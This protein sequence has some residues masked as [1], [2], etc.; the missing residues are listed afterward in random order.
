MADPLSIA[1]LV[2]GVIS[3]GLQVADGLTD[4]LDAVKGR[5]EDLRS[6]KQGATEMRDL[7]STIRDLSPQVESSWPASATTVKRHV[8]SCQIELGALDALLSEL[9]QPSLSNSRLRSMLDDTKKKLSYPFERSQISR[10]EERLTKVNNNLQTALQVTELNIAITSANQIR[11]VHGLV[12]S[13]SQSQT[14]LQM[15]S[16]GASVSLSTAREIP[17]A[18][19]SGP[20]VPLDSFQTA[21]SLAAKPSLLSSSIKTLEEKLNTRQPTNCDL[22]QVCLCRPLR[23]AAHYQQNWGQLAFLHRV[24]STRR[25]L[26]DC[27]LSQIDTETRSSK[28]TVEYFGL[29]KLFQTAFALSFTSTRG[30]GGR[31]ISPGFTYYPTVDYDVAPAFRVMFLAGRFI[32]FNENWNETAIRTL[33]CCYD[34]IFELYRRK[35]ASPKDITLY[36]ESLMHKMQ[37]KLSRIH[38]I[39]ADASLQMATKL[40]ACGVPVTTYNSS[41]HTPAISFLQQRYNDD[42]LVLGL[43][44]RLLPE[45]GIPLVQEKQGIKRYEFGFRCLEGFLEDSELAEASGCGPLSLAARAG[46]ERLVQEL[47]RKY[48]QSLEETNDLGHTPVHLAIKHPPCLRLILEAGG[49]PM[50]ERLKPDKWNYTPFASA[51]RLGYKASVLAL[52]SAGSHLDHKCMFWSADSCLDEVLVALKQRRDELKLLALE[53]LTQAE[54]RS[55]GLHEGKV[56]DC[57]ASSVQ[58]LL[59]EKGILVSLRLCECLYPPVYFLDRPTTTPLFDK[60]WALGFRDING[61]D[62]YGGVPVTEN[63]LHFEKA[64][65]LIKHGADYWTPFSER[66]RGTNTSNITA[67]PAHFLSGCIGI[68]CYIRDED[69]NKYAREVDNC[70]WLVEKL[71]EVQVRDACSCPCSRGG[72]TPLKA[73]SDFHRG[74]PDRVR[75]ERLAQ[76][77]VK[78]TRIFQANFSE[79]DLILTLRRMTFD[80]LG[81]THTCCNFYTSFET[82]HKSLYTFE[83]VDEINSEQTHLLT[84]FDDLLAEFDEIA[85]EDRNGVPLIVD[86]LEEFWMRRWLP[87][88]EEVLDDLNGDDLTTKERSAAEDVGV[89][90]DLQPV[91]DKVEKNEYVDYSSPEYVMK[92][93]KKIL[94]K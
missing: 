8:H 16:I 24:S 88:M 13:L 39:I 57:Y 2:T 31:S 14:S 22:S 67:T 25:H 29:T 21:I 62:N 7:L 71:M 27:P 93:L 35:K 10:L 44:K 54:A 86:D 61:F 46:D 77:C 47:I 83:E 23:K 1:G 28:F 34:A 49:S 85:H 38:P 60:L 20:L 87:R 73:F 3:L 33:Q 17:G 68:P 12:L 82:Y 53:H 37:H 32:W 79:T 26:P 72:C 42:S 9:S 59:V 64:R 70:Q 18:T 45:P 51:C 50:L 48:P 91:Q 92:Q 90:W 69:D 19:N 78:L 81:L 4:Y 6:A 94:D 36:G 66:T 40:I 76:W 30:A 56:L 65:W 74:S 5:S 15:Q 41:G 58:R 52:L 43:I 84:L 55:F 11:E 80:G 63:R 89:K 75:V